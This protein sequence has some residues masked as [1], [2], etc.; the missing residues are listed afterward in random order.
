MFTINC[1]TFL[2]NLDDVWRG[3]I[4][5]KSVCFWLCLYA[6][7]CCVYTIHF[8]RLADSSVNTV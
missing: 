6:F 5:L 2:A 4:K 7:P 8:I 3:Y 1:K